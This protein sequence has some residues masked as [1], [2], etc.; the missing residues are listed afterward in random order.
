MVPEFRSMLC[1]NQFSSAFRGGAA[2]TAMGG[3]VSDP[4]PALLAKEAAAELRESPDRVG[5]TPRWGVVA[6]AALAALAAFAALPGVGNIMDGRLRVKFRRDAMR[7]IGRER[8]TGTLSSNWASSPPPLLAASLA[9]KDRANELLRS[10]PRPG[11]LRLLLLIV[12]V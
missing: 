5:S 1:R 8:G 9:K 12:V 7:P 11:S 10:M 3:V 2:A 6:L 4:R